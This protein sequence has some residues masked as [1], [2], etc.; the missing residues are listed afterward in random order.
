MIID[1]IE[2]AAKYAVISAGIK[3][4]LDYILATDLENTEVGKYELGDGVKAIVS[5]Y[6]SKE[7]SAGV[8]ESH[9]KFI[10][11]QYIISGEEKMGYLP[12]EGQTPSTPYNEEKDVMFFTEPVSFTAFKKG[13]FS[14]Y[15]PEDIHQPCIQIDSPVQVKKLVIKV[16]V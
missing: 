2:N 16:P 3:K 5:E 9:K 8:I 1:K 6:Q 11:I 14:I 10:D 12:L 7:A 13:M 15:F 4:G